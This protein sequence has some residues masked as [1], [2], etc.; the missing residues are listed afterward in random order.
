MVSRAERSLPKA[1]LKV[2]AA[3]TKRAC[4]SR[5]PLS[6]LTRKAAPI[7]QVTV[8]PAAISGIGTSS[9][10]APP[11]CCCVPLGVLAMPGLDAG[12]AM[13]KI[14]VISTAASPDNI[15]DD[16]CLPSPLLAL[17]PWFISVFEQ[18]TATFHGS[19]KS[20]NPCKRAASHRL[21]IRVELDSPPAKA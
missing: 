10:R 5:L 20:T 3:S 18:P 11:S 1:S 9:S 17:S 13:R 14:N 2:V 21:R 15:P 4:F 7:A 6:Q 19:E 16:S 12:V 8:R